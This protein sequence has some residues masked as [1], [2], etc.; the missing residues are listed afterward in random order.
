[1]KSLSY[2][3]TAY[4]SAWLAATIG[5]LYSAT[6][7]FAPRP[8]PALAAALTGAFLL[9]G[10]IFSASALLG[11]YERLA[12]SAGGYAT[13]AIVFGLAGALSAT[14]HGGY[15]LA[16]AINPPSQTASDL[17]SAVDPRGLGTFGLAGI[18]ILAFAYLM[19]R[20]ASFPLNLSYLG[21][22]S[23]ALLVVIYL[24]R[25]IILSASN[26]FVLAVAALEGFAVNPIWYVWL[27]LALRREH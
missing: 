24:A 2:R 5:F 18:S 16:N 14:L 17:P 21:F 8:A 27:G 26:P 9:L 19:G 4:P 6:F 7:V 3:H 12:P 23:G 11:L 15:D 1:M 20:E 22:I 13:W 25:L 10:G